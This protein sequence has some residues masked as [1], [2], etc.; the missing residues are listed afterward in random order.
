[1]GELVWSALDSKM[2][3]QFVGIHAGYLRE[4]NLNM[5]KFELMERINSFI[6]YDTIYSR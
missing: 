1:V 6:N 5:N 3:W 4:M 2:S